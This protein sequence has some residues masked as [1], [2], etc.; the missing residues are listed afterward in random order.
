MKVC[1]G[2]LTVFLLSLS[3]RGQYMEKGWGIAGS[4]EYWSVAYLFWLDAGQKIDADVVKASLTTYYD[5]LVAGAVIRRNLTIPPGTIKRYDRHVRL[6]GEKTDDAQ[7]LCPR[8]TLYC[9]GAY[10][11]VPGNITQAIGSPDMG[12]AQRAQA[13]IFVRT[14]TA[15]NG[16]G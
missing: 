6:H 11:L 16:K 13:E 10:C 15:P 4:D 2:L 1:P 9:P 8:E 14:V 5:D 7:L 12:Q 3:A